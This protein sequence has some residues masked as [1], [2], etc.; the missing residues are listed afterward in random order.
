VIQIK[1]TGLD[2]YLDGDGGTTNIKALILGRPGT[3]KTRGASYWKRPFLIDGEKSRSV[4]NDRPTPYAEVSCAE[5]LKEIIR[6]LKVEAGKPNRKY[7]TVIVD[8]VDG[9]Q[10]K[11]IKERLAKVKRDRMEAYEG[12][13]DAVNTPLTDFIDELRELPYNVVVNV[14]LKEAGKV[15]KKDDPG[16]A[17]RGDDTITQAQAW[18]P[19]L[20]GGIRQ[21]LA[22]WFDLVGLMENTWTVKDG[23][24]VIGRQIRWQPTPELPYLKDRLYA[25][26]PVTPV[27]FEDADYERLVGYLQKKAARLKP[28]EVV[29]EIG[30]PSKAAPP[31]I[32]GG[33]VKAEPSGVLPRPRAAAKPKGAKAEGAAKDAPEPAPDPTPEVPS[34]EGPAPEAV[35]APLDQVVD[36]EVVTEAAAE[37]EVAPE[38]A[39]AAVQ[40]VL[41]G[42]VVAEEVDY[43]AQAEKATNRE[44]IRA[45]WDAA[46]TAGQLTSALKARLTV[47]GR[48]LAA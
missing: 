7:D 48:K 40:E 2:D 25:F 27:N 30:E 9:I 13:Y 12:D 28:G 46:K 45:I 21:K 31:D 4:L 15:A 38:E 32:P 26:P 10:L 29:E 23:K 34:A 11:L 41:G 14:H 20:A 1:T 33:P 42:E 22:G 3:G 18:D 19:D 17:A 16:P 5:D 6:Y 37:P 47:L 43:A 36:A 39:V 24:K 8:T 35:T 44:E